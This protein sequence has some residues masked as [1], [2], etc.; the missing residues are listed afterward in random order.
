[1]DEES[2]FAAALKKPTAAARRA[3]VEE[4]C[5]GDVALRQ[6]VEQL[7]AAHLRT[8]GILDRPAR[9]PEWTEVAAEVTPGADQDS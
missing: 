8:L 9:P 6:R 1:M 2:L 4:A 3:F 5:A 7:L